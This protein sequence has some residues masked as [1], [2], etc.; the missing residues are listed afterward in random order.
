M[1]TYQDYQWRV[2]VKQEIERVIEVENQ[3][4]TAP[5][6][7]LYNHVA[8]IYVTEDADYRNIKIKN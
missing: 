2:T 1:K 8:I 6:L 4:G 3:S 5:S 7:D